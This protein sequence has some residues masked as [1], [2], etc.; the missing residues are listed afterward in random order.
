[1]GP[2]YADGR[3]GEAETLASCYR[4]CIRIANE[5]AIKS[6]AFPSISTGAYGYPVM[7]AAEI[8]VAAVVEALASANRLTRVRFVLFDAATLQAY[9][10]AAEKMRDP[11]T[12]LPYKREKGPQ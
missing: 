10:A 4:E 7:E 2:I 6:L 11:K 1:V 12:A 9:V 8:A 3:R 5:H